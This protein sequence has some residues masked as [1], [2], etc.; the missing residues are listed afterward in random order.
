MVT[1]AV[2]RIATY[3]RVS[4]EDQRERETI[5][6]QTDELARQLQTDPGVELVARYVDDGVSGT[7][8]FSQRSAGSRLLGDA[9]LGRFDEVWVYKIDRLGRDDVDPLVVWHQLQA[10]GVTVYSITE[11]RI[12]PFMYAIRVAVAAQERRTFL[13][14]SSAGMNRAAREGRYTGGI[15]PLG[16]AAVGKRP[17]ARLIPSDKLMWGDLS[18]SGVVRRIYHHLVFDRWSCRRIAHEFNSLGMPTAYQKDGRGVRGERT[19][20]KW[21]PGRIRNLVTNP[22]YRGELQYGRRTSLPGGREV[23]SAPVPRLVSDEVWYAAQETLALHRIMPKNAKR[24]YPLRSLIRCGS[25][26]LRYSGTGGAKA[27]YRCN[28]QMVERGPIEGKCTSKSIKGA[29]LEPLVYNDILGWLRRPGELL[30][31]LQPEVDGREEAAVAVAE[32]VTLRSALAELDAQRDRALDA[33]IRGR[34]PKEKLDEVLD[35]IAADNAEVARR[36]ETLRSQEKDDDLGQQIGEDLLESLQ[37]RTYDGLS[38]E[39]QQEVVRLLVGRIVVHTEI[40]DDGKKRATI[41]IDYRFPTVAPTCTG[42]DSWPT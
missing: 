33:Y 11:G 26:G 22:I 39:E 30:K 21:R 9:A 5:R 29:F 8:P 10:L 7:I 41:V 4:S 13:D 24:V 3:E 2:R 14:R 35:R 16:Y 20:G 17:D 23:I 18:E 34:L 27:W 25:C 6:T 15:V 32:S 40:L 12:D 1:Q 31:E 38:D 28:G 36:L 37:R 42:M 19:Q